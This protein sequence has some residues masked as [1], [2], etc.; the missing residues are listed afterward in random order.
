MIY[1]VGSAVA[2]ILFYFLSK[3]I[4]KSKNVS[5]LESKSESDETY[6]KPTTELSKKPGRNS[7]LYPEDDFGKMEEG[8]SDVELKYSPKKIKE[9]DNSNRFGKSPL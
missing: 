1:L 9:D 3:S 4:G 6:M 2:V 8:K 5:D 7:W